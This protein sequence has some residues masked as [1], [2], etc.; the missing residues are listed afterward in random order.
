M[1]N[2]MQYLAIIE[3]E[4]PVKSD[5]IDMKIRCK[6]DYGWDS[7]TPH[8]TVFNLIQPTSNE[9]RLI[10][11]FERNIVNIS[12]FQINLC[13]FDYF[14]IPTYTLYVKLKD[15]KQFSEM[16]RYIRKFCKPILKSVKDYSP[17]YNTKDAHLTIAKGISELEFLKAW[18]NW[19]NLEYQS[20]TI[21]NRI[22]LLRRPFTYANFKYEIVGKYPFL[23]QGPLDPQTTLFQ[24]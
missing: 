22:F 5:V 12:P 4:D 1:E 7:S 11:C 8:F 23:G 19:E 14:S 15:E 17:H 20:S 2:H 18:P 10:K 9:K 16:A 13:G 3:P 24:K 6:N 21:A